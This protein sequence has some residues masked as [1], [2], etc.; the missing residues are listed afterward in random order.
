MK[1]SSKNK[2]VHRF[3]F[4]G[5]ETDV[6]IKRGKEELVLKKNLKDFSSGLIEL[7][8]WRPSGGGYVCGNSTV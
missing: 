6:I 5:I 2:N 8:L 1:I 3:C 4:V 7:L